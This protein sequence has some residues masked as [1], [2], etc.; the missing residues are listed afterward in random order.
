MGE[1]GMTARE[2]S[3]WQELDAFALGEH[4]WAPQA[5]LGEPDF[6]TREATARFG[7]RELRFAPTD[8]HGAHFALA[9]P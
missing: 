5:T 9:R 2:E 1:D 6:R 7:S 8:R 4:S 3:V